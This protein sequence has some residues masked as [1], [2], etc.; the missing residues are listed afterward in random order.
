MVQGGKLVCSGEIISGALSSSLHKLI[1][2][3]KKCGVRLVAIEQPFA[4]RAVPRKTLI[5][6]SW[7]AGAICGACIAMD[8][9]AKM[10]SLR[11]VRRLISKKLV[12]DGEV[13]RWLQ[14]QGVI[15]G[16]TNVHERDAV[17]VA[18]A[19]S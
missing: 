11:E 19:V 2:D 1:I 13:K 6:L 4:G 10:V 16:R 5:R 7:I 8:M 18:L 9:P 12:G 3:W 14:E 15:D 17:M